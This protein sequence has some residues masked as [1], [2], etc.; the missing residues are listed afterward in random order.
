MAFGRCA[1]PQLTASAPGPGRPT[2]REGPR[3]KVHFGRFSSVEIVAAVERVEHGTLPGPALEAALPPAL[4]PTGHQT[5]AGV[6]LGP[7]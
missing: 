1:G 7:H 3:T 4:E 5:S 6:R 2:R